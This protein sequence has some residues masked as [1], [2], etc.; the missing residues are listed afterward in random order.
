MEDTNGSG[1]NG[2]P[3]DSNV[4]TNP[5]DSNVPT[6]PEEDDTTAFS[7]PQKGDSN[8]PTEQ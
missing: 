2:K 1:D 6:N 7:E 8:V 3:G 4:P 5:G